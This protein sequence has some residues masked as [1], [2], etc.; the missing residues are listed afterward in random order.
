MLTEWF[1]L[2]KA[3]SNYKAALL[4]VRIV[5]LE[6]NLAVTIQQNNGPYNSYQKVIMKSGENV[7]SYTLSN[8]KFMHMSSYHN[9]KWN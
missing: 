3:R 8:L 5:L 7:L 9:I 4:A 2:T 1:F 6:Y